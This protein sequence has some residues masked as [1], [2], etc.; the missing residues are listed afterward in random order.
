MAQYASVNGTKAALTL[1]TKRTTINT[2]KRYP[3]YSLKRTTIN[4]W[5]RKLSPQGVEALK[6]RKGRPNLMNDEW[7]AKTNDIIIGTRQAGTVVSR[8]MVINIGSGKANEP[9]LLKEYGGPLELTEDWARN[10]LKSM[11]WVKKKG[12]TGK[13]EPSDGFLAEE[14]F[15]FQRAISTAVLENDIPR[16]LIINLD[17]T[18]LGYVSPG[19]YTFCMRGSENVP[20]KGMDDKRQITATFAVSATGEFLPIQ[21]I[22]QGKT[23]R[24]LPKFRFPKGFHVTYTPNHWSNLEK[25]LDF[26][27][28]IIFPYLKKVKQQL[29][30][31]DEQ[32]SLV[33]MDCFRGQDNNDTTFYICEKSFCIIVL[34]PRNLTNKF[35]SRHD[36]QKHLNSV[37]VEIF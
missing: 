23:K 26:F 19:K 21:V 18:P 16:D 14:K 11:E 20:I 22:Y 31:P 2:W 12:T 35:Q 30:Y 27:K 1:Y 5:K 10:V 33:T 37:F 3:K 28:N 4:T 36:M 15:T 29:G 13:T 9:N 32:W 6:A 34:V 8:R 24:C 17:Q 25:C 7:L